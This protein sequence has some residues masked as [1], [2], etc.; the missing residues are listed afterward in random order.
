MRIR[1]LLVPVPD[2]DVF[3]IRRATRFKSAQATAAERDC[4]SSQCL[5]YPPPVHTPYVP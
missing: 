4:A 3:Q 5:D 1:G 2:S